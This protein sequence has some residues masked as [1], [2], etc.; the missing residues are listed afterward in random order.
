MNYKMIIYTLGWILLFESA[1]MMVPAIT[2]LIYAEFHSLAAFLIS[3]GACL[4][5]GALMSVRKPKNRT[6]RSRDG[7]VIVSLSWIV[8]S[9]F[10]AIPFMLTG[11]T[12]SYIDAL[13]ETASGFTTTGATIF[14]D[15]E[16]LPNA[17]I[18]WRSF[19]HWVGGM[20]ILVFI[21]AFL[22]LS[23][24]TNMYIMR[25]ESPGPT[26]SKPVPKIKTT[27]MLLYVVYIVLTVLEFVLLVCG[28]MPVFYAINTAFSTAGTGGF[29]FYNS[30]MGSFSPYIQIVITV[31]MALFAINFSSYFF[32]LRGKIK[33]AF[34]S[35][36]KTF[37]VI[38]G[39]S[40]LLI[41]LN[42]RSMYGSFGESMRHSF[43]SVSSIM[44]TTG[45][46]T[47]NFDMWPAFSQTLIV[48][49]MII[50]ACAGS[51]GGGI[52]V[53]RIIVMWKLIRREMST[54]LHPKQVKKISMDGQIIERDVVRSIYG[55]FFC[56]IL[57]FVISMVILAIDGNDL[58]TNFTSVAATIGNVGPGLAK[59][60]P[61]GNYGFFS[62]LSKLMLTFNMLAGRLELYPML[63]LFVPSTWKKR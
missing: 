8:L 25:A 4:A 15:V 60:G 42:I 54:A 16:I 22:P 28:K 46:A 48:L 57:L 35:E 11:V 59:V 56:Y 53:S 23:G 5:V 27:A 21:M 9:A 17:V 61:I 2:A 26:V 55:F 20:G 14:S 36:I 49:V 29:G 52:K 50:G 58:I 33:E 34:T 30:S 10:G 45:F 37:L 24:G 62:P 47:E 41:A 1:F 18:M 12:N 63:L 13:F 44:S 3:A 7:F 51:T 39:A 38:L 32:L 43:F 40:S 31:F 6:L 19:T